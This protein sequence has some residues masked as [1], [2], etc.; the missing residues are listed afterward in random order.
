MDLFGPSLEDLYYM[1]GQRFSIKTVCMVAKQMITRVQTIHEKHLLY[2]NIKLDHFLI[3]LP[4]SKNAQTIH[5]ID[6]GMA[7]LWRD[8]KTN[9]HI[10]YREG[11]ELSGTARFMSINSHFGREQSR[12]DDLESLGYVF[13]YLLRG[14]LPWE[15]LKAATNKENY[16]KVGEKKRSIAFKDLCEGFPEEFG[17]Y[18]THVQCLG[19][20]ENPDYDFLRDLFTKILKST[21]EVEDGVFDWMLLPDW[22]NWD[23]GAFEGSSRRHLLEFLFCRCGG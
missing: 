5:V 15:G 3:G 12:R 23:A 14:S 10:P 6:F 17:V 9:L 2:R 22:K 1:C 11:K 20:E 19:F 16:E 18:L 13:L 21:G 8:P 7:K 4:G